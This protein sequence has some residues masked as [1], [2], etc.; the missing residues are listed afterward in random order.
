MASYLPNLKTEN[1]SLYTIP[2]F[3]VRTLLFPLPDITKY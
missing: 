3:W 2:V 1:I